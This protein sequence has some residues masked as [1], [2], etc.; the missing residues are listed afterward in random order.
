M[1]RLALSVPMATATPPF[2]KEIIIVERGV[3]PLGIAGDGGALEA[4][5]GGAGGLDLHHWMVCKN[6]NYHHWLRKQAMGAPRH[7][8]CNCIKLMHTWCK[9]VGACP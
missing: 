8:H 4:G 3:A 6:L 7:P 5:D 1:L 2:T 9:I